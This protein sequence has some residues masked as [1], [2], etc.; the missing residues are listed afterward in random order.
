MEGQRFHRTTDEE[1][2]QEAQAWLLRLTSGRATVADAQAFREWCARSPEHAQ[3]FART[4]VLWEELGRMPGTSRRARSA[5]GSSPRVIV[6]A[7]A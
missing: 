2:R 7:R 6:A 4:R 1:L 5:A 3:A